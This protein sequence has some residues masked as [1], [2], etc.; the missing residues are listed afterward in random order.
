MIADGVKHTSVAKQT[1]V[2]IAS[3]F[4][5]EPKWKKLTSRI[6]RPYIMMPSTSR[7]L[8]AAAE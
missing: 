6:P 5:P 3:V 8:R 7:I 1:G 4:A 2:F